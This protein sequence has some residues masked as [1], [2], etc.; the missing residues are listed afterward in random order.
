MMSQLTIQEQDVW[1]A[2]IEF[3]HFSTEQ[4]GTLYIS[5][6]FAAA[7]GPN[8]IQS[9]VVETEYGTQL[10]LLL[11]SRPEGKKRM[12]EV[13]YSEPLNHLGQY[14]W[15]CVYTGNELLARF[16]QIETLI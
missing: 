11:P 9:K 13:F 10:L 3:D 16:T 5:G 1:D 2:W 8:P 6:E 12:K 15:I 7:P 4:F 14:D